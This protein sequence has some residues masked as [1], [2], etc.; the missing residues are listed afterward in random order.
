MSSYD[1]S[2]AND[3]MP[4]CFLNDSSMSI[5]VDW[6][7]I[8]PSL[9]F[10]SSL[11]SETQEL[12][13]NEKQDHCKHRSCMHDISHVDAEKQVESKRDTSLECPKNKLH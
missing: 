1:N 2:I 9:F 3:N 5:E 6:L 4:Q 13:Y 11:D 12:M 7:W 10:L 8:L